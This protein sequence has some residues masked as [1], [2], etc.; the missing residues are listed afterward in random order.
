M[1]CQFKKLHTSGNNYPNDHKFGK[2][3]HKDK[4]QT[5][6]TTKNSGDF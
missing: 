1:E 2:N 4:Q 6:R 3:G 5:T